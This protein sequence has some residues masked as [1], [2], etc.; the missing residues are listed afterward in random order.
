MNPARNLEEEILIRLNV[1]IHLL[2]ESQS[3]SKTTVASK[4]SQLTEIGV[5]ATDT[6]KILGKP[7]KD[8]TSSLAKS[9]KRKG[10]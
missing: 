1:I 4:I 8:V 9:K 10:K 6:A 7:L 5:S 2:F 3:E